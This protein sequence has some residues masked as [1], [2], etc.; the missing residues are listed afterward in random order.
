MQTTSPN[1]V[2]AEEMTKKYGYPDW[3]SWRL[4]NWGVKWNNNPYGDTTIKNNKL[5]FQFDTPWGVPDPVFIKLS[6]LY[7]D[8][9]I[10]NYVVE[11][12][13]FFKGT[14]KY[15]N[16]IIDAD[17]APYDNCEEPEDE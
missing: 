15:K 4:N 14:I 1:S 7:P 10:E 9:E 6:L 12:A 16:G 8:I 11:E 17:I 13:G 5:M 2:N 3:Y